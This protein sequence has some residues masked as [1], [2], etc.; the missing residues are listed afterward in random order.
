MASKFSLGQGL[1]ASSESESED[2]NCFFIDLEDGA[3]RP[4]H[5]PTSRAQV[6][7]D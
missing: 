6:G 3:N 1:P 7:C 5:V 2:A 4:Q